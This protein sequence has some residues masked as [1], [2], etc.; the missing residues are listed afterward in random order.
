MSSGMVR[1]TK[2]M[3]LLNT[4]V[5]ALNKYKEQKRQH[6][7]IKKLMNTVRDLEKNAAKDMQEIR[8]SISMIQKRLEI[9]E[10]KL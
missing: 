1:D 8:Q 10:G 9:V 3:A 2:N 4:D 7:T 5:D 6:N